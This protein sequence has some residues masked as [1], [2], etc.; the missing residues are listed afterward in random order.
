[1]HGYHAGETK[2]DRNGVPAISPDDLGTGRLPL[3]PS[4]RWLPPALC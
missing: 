3:P 4:A 1:L 2:L